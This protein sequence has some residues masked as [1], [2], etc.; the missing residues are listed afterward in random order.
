MQ[1]LLGIVAIGLL[2][3][4]SA[5]ASPMLVDPTAT[6]SDVNAVITSSNCL[7]CFIDASLS[8]DLEAAA[9]WLDTGD[10]F[11]FDFIDVVVGGL[12][13]TAEVA[14]DATLALA[15]P[16]TSAEGN[17]FGAFASFLFIFNG[18]ELTWSQ[19]D[20]VDLGDGTF[21]GIS[22]EDLFEFR[23]GNT[24][25]VSATISRFDAAAAV[26]EPGTAALLILGMFGLWFASRR[27]PV[28]QSR[29]VSATPT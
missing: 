13:G 14:I 1:R 2:A 29:F 16:E 9:A 19:P 17:A 18:I 22:F 12:V 4:G 27:R 11:T 20:V 10:S 3:F 26:P 23:V 15:S 24:F 7:G 28:G 21:L 6:G 8:D 25:T 5:H